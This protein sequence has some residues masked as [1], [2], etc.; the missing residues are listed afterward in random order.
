MPVR[1]QAGL[2]YGGGAE[3][4]LTPRVYDYLA[5]EG[6]D[7]FEIL[8]GYNTSERTC[9]VVPVRVPLSTTSAV[10]TGSSVGER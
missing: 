6:T 8:S 4:R 9:A 5:P 2:R 1:E 3:S 7:Q 10:C